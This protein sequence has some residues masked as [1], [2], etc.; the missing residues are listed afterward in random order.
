MHLKLI[1]NIRTEWYLIGSRSHWGWMVG[2]VAHGDGQPQ[3]LLNMFQI[4]VWFKVA[5]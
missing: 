2:H 5:L 4:V 3:I 1:I